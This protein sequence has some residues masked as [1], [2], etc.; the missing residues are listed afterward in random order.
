[1]TIVNV[2]GNVL[3]FYA[4]ADLPRQPDDMYL[5]VHKAPLAFRRVDLEWLRE[6]HAPA[7]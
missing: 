6:E 2:I 3:R 1:V 7:P 5:S 4:G